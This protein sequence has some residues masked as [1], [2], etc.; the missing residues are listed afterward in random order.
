MVWNPVRFADAIGH[1]AEDAILDMGAR[2]IMGEDGRFEPN[3]PMTRA[4]FAAVV[5]RALGLKTANPADGDLP[6]SDV[7][8]R[9]W[10]RTRSSRGPKRRSWCGG[11]S[12]LRN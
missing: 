2:L 6:F 10:P 9:N 5:V 1:W 4:E 3:R 8:P 7:K 11:C 12:N